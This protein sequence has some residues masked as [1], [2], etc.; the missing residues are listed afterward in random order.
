MNVYLIGFMGTGKTAVSKELAKLLPYCLVDMDS[1]IEDLA[2]MSIPDIFATMGEEKFR[3]M[4]TQLL[5][6]LGE[7][8]AQIVSCG[9]GVVLR[10]ENVEIM[11]KTGSTVLLTATAETVWN[12]TKNN[13]HRPLLRDKKGPE[14]IQPMLDAREPKYK[15]AADMTIATDD[16]KPSEI[17]AK[18]VEQLA[19]E[20]KLN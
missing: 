9:G 17:A 19:K 16:L 5:T 3:Q 7:E 15:V 18:I 8:G 13:D 4:E 1:A 10:P 11:K 6:A 20:D 14:D 2:A 12:R